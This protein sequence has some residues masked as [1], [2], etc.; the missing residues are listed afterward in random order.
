M[1]GQC[2][3]ARLE[4]GAGQRGTQGGITAEAC[5]SLGVTQLSL[6]RRLLS[7]DEKPQPSA[8]PSSMLCHPLETSTS[9]ELSVSTPAALGGPH[10]SPNPLH[11]R[12]PEPAKQDGGQR[13]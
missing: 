4:Q 8:G 12:V 5:G 9:P 6:L 7:H 3:R 11:C 1:S 13:Q 10:A 2:E